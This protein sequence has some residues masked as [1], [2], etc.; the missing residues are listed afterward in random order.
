MAPLLTK[1]LDCVVVLGNAKLKVFVAAEVVTATVDALGDN[2]DTVR[3]PKLNL[4]ASDDPDT[5][6]DPKPK[7][8]VSCVVFGGSAAFMPKTDATGVLVVGTVVAD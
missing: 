1:S 3:L 4:F 5:D 6:R 8:V 2:A 7:L